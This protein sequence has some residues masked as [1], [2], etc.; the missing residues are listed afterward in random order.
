MKEM[1]PDGMLELVPKG[2]PQG[3]RHWR[4]RQLAL[5]EPFESHPGLT[6]LRGAP[7]RLATS[8]VPDLGYALPQAACLP[9]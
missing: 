1:Y 7:P 4:Q 9:K 5:V 8:P 3:L 2:D 6:Y